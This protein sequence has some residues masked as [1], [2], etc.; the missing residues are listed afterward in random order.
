MNENYEFAELSGEALSKVRE[1][2]SELRNESGENITIIAY[3]NTDRRSAPACRADVN[4][5]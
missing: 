2:E 5:E 1:L 4:G 3:T